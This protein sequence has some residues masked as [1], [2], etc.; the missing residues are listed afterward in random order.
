[1]PC[2]EVFYCVYGDGVTEVNKKKK[3]VTRASHLGVEE[4]AFGVAHRATGTAGLL[5]QCFLC[6]GHACSTLGDGVVVAGVLLIFFF[7][8]L[9]LPLLV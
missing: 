6:S 4:D 1:M 3:K 7:L 2:H 8:F 5:W 9:Q